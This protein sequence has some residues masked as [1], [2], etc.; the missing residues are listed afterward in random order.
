MN[1]A[2]Y[3][4]FIHAAWRSFLAAEG[5]E[6]QRQRCNEFTQ[7]VRPDQNKK[8]RGS[9]ARRGFDETKSCI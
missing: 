7:L 1:A 9:S 5:I 8:S 4:G 6:E 3:E 2:D